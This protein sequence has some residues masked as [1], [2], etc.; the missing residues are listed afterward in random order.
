MWKISFTFSQR[1]RQ[2]K[3]QWGWG[4]GGG[5]GL[6][7]TGKL[8]EEGWTKFETGYINANIRGDHL[9]TP[10]LYH[11]AIPEKIQTGW[12]CVCVCVGG[13]VED[14]EFPGVSKK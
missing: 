13:G 6:D 14:M 12:V 9:S 10:L 1:N 3:K 11:G 2:Q 8:G 5:G 4:G 7:V